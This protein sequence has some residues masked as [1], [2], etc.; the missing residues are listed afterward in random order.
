MKPEEILPNLRTYDDLYVYAAINGPRETGR[1]L[2]L[3]IELGQ[4]GGFMDDP[5]DFTTRAMCRA[6]GAGIDGLKEMPSSYM[7]TRYGKTFYNF[8]WSGVWKEP[9]K[10]E[11]E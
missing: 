5:N 1:I 8:M 3:Y 9:T 6:A 11:T 2:R 7:D 4:P 10:E